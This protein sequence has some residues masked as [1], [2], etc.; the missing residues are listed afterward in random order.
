[1]PPDGRIGG[2]GGGLTDRQLCRGCQ[3][4]DRIA[5]AAAGG[6]LAWR[7]RRA[8]PACG[9]EC[10]QSMGMR[11]PHG[12]ERLTVFKGLLTRRGL[13]CSRAMSLALLRSGLRYC[14]RGCISRPQRRP[15]CRRNMMGC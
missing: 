12:I 15:T 11:G 4:G 10:S 3:W 8:L 1:M 5:Q 13:Q 14:L 2:A 7:S 6:A 9:V